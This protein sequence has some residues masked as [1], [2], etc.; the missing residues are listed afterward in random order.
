MFSLGNLVDSIAVD[1]DPGSIAVPSLL[2]DI[3]TG[4][5]AVYKVWYGYKWTKVALDRD[6]STKEK[7]AKAA[8]GHSL[9]AGFGDSELSLKN[10]P[11]IAIA[12][13]TLMASSVFEY[14]HSKQAVRKAYLVWRRAVHSNYC[15]SY[16]PLMP[17]QLFQLPTEGQSGQMDGFKSRL[18]SA[19]TIEAGNA[20]FSS[21]FFWIQQ[22]ALSSFHLLAAAFNCYG[23]FMYAIMAFS[24]SKESRKEG[25]QGMA[26]NYRYAVNELVEDKLKLLEKVQANQ[27]V[28][29]AISMRMHLPFNAKHCISLVSGAMQVARGMSNV[30][31]N[32]SDTTESSLKMMLYSFC[33]TLTG[34]APSAFLPVKDLEKRALKESELKANALKLKIEDRL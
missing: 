19:S 6:I 28:L 25:L 1:V 11:L 8:L 20:L 33:Y 31:N 9:R 26:F 30:T 2:A 23:C 5:N 27:K 17:S 13:L 3:S 21:G 24:L 16:L 12:H 32:M 18:F 14:A 10:A 22:V 29:D 34:Q 15:T 7:I 4:L